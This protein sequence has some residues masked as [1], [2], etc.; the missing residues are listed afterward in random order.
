MATTQI[1]FAAV[2]YIGAGHVPALIAETITA[3]SL[4]PAAGA[5]TTTASAP[6]TSGN[7]PVARVSTDTLVWVVFGAAPNATNEAT[8]LLIQA[9]A[10]E[11]IVVNVGDK[12]SVM[13]A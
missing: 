10:T 3:E 7:R 1:A 12:A 11:Y 2:G 8:R 6:Q 13:T 9:G 5:Q 4:T